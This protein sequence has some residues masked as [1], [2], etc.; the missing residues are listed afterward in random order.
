MTA[1]P[2]SACCAFDVAVLGSGTVALMACLRPR[3]NLNATLGRAIPSRLRAGT[4]TDLV[5]SGEVDV[6]CTAL[7][8][9]AIAGA[10]SWSGGPSVGVD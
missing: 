1:L 4:G 8:D 2:M 10:M 5:L 9:D 3:D 7:F 6:H